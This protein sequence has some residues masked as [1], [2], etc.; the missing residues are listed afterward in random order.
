[1]IKDV[2]LCRINQHSIN[3]YTANDPATKASI[4]ERFIRTI[5]SLMYKYFT[6]T[7]TKK[8]LDIL[9]SIVDIYNNRFHNTI[10]MKP[11]EVNEYNIL[12]VWRNMNENE[13]RNVFNDKKP[14]FNVGT[15]VRLS[16]PK[17]I[18]EKGYEPRWSNEVFTVNKVILSYPLTYRVIDQDGETLNS[19]F[20][21]DELQ[22][23]IKTS[24]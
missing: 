1:M 19:L 13:P 17:H 21:E 9:D 7:N 20:Y 12:K 5:K 6:Y 8:Y 24:K 15:F 14:K 11:S 22:E 10:R 23:I 16:N 18:F 3:F 4:C 2:N